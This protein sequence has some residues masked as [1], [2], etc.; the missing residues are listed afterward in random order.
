MD[1]SDVGDV[2]ADT[3]ALQVAEVPR[4]TQERRVPRPRLP[5]TPPDRLCGDVRLSALAGADQMLRLGLV[6]G[7]IT[8]AGSVAPRRCFQR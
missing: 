5:L 8:P 3:S 2:C 6:G 4:L 1:A 7:R